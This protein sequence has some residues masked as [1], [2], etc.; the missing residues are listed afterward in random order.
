MKADFWNLYQRAPFKKQSM[1]FSATI[2]PEAM[3]S[4]RIMMHEPPS[5]VKIIE[6][7]S[8]LD[9]LTQFFTIIPEIKKY[10][11]LERLLDNLAF[12]QC[13]IFV[14]RI[15]KAR[16]LM[17]LLKQ[18]LYNPI[19]MHSN[20]RQE[21]RIVNYDLFKENSSKILVATDLFGRGVDI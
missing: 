11:K 10:D 20:L 13:I 17:D 3:N 19:S 14:N 4:M 7:T 1:M 15:E 21:E 16:K 18:K 5:E 6:D 9:G 2:S 12:N 8:I